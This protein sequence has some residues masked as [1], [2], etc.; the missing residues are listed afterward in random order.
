MSN[1]RKVIYTDR[2][3]VRIWLPLFCGLG[4]LV[5]GLL[6]EPVSKGDLVFGTIALLWAGYEF[7]RRLKT[8]AESNS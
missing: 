5:G 1:E 4:I 6:S 3:A 7:R 8:N 2:Y